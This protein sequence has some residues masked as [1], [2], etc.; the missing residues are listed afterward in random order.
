MTAANTNN[1]VAKELSD[2]LA[3]CKGQG[4]DE[5]TLRTGLLTITI[6]NFVNRIG[7]ANTISLFQAL[8]EQIGSGM[9]DRYIDPNTNTPQAAPYQAAGANQSYS[10]NA[11]PGNFIQPNGVPSNGTPPAAQP[12]YAQN[13]HPP[14][15]EYQEH[16]SPI[17]PTRRRLNQ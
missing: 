6:A 16:P 14:V 15:T 3:K 13:V 7:M 1:I 2:A 4:V 8:P 9:F 17:P 12:Q 10:N 5:Q 11:L